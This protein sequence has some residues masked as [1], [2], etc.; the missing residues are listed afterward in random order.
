M[1]FSW[2]HETSLNYYTSWALP[3]RIMALNMPVWLLS[4]CD[5]I[6][7]YIRCVF[8][9]SLCLALNCVLMVRS[10]VNHCASCMRFPNRNVGRALS[11]G[12][13]WAAN[14]L[15]TKQWWKCCRLAFI[16][17]KT[18]EEPNL[19][20]FRNNNSTFLHA[21]HLLVDISFSW[22]PNFKGKSCLPLRVYPTSDQGNLY[23][24]DI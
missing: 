10:W 11:L 13:K 4:D 9:C 14:L 3:Y 15:I 1:S 12:L 6:S 16:L 8:V 5:F 18:K 17:E 20:C 22:V 19:C 21:Y 2:Y 23:S 7:V 24:I